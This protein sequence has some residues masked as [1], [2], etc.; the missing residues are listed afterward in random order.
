MKRGMRPRLEKLELRELLSAAPLKTFDYV[1]PQK[2]H[3]SITLYGQG[4]LAGTSVE[5]SGALDLVFA[6]TNL[7]SGI[8][9]KVSGGNHKVFVSTIHDAN[10]A[11]GDLSGIGGDEIGIINLKQFDL[12]PGGNINLTTGVGS[13]FLNA[14][15]ANAQVH[16]TAPTVPQSTSSTT[17]AASTT[18]FS[19]SSTTVTSGG[20][21]AAAAS[22]TNNNPGGSTFNPIGGG[23]V[24]A[25]TRVSAG[26]S[27]SQGCRDSGGSAG[28]QR[29]AR[30]FS[31]RRR[32]RSRRTSVS[33]ACHRRIKRAH[34]AEIP[35][36]A[37]FRP[38]R[39]ATSP[40][41]RADSASRASAP[42]RMQ[43]RGFRAEP[44]TS[45]PRR[46]QLLREPSRTPIR[47]RE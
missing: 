25:P 34:W 13:L 15:G 21:T 43:A 30:S 2:T 31:T 47:R 23:A 33:A 11:I 12:L 41:V 3:V 29:Q 42:L 7:Q 24:R 9:A 5:A 16:L 32:R 8:V 39:R 46:R 40:W 36:S 18:N 44:S 37:G 17:G 4:T 20:S 26:W 1:T 27:D 35:R 10:L 22:T 6:N 28:P 19:A 38:P 14:M 45:M